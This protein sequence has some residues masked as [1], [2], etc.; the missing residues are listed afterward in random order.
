MFDLSYADSKSRPGNQVWCCFMLRVKFEEFKLRREFSRPHLLFSMASKIS[1]FGVVD[2]SHIMIVLT[3]QY[4]KE[5]L[6]VDAC[7]R[8]RLISH[9]GDG[10][11]LKYLN[12]A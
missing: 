2:A 7:E 11:I 10:R 3:F 12:R 5:E 4:S 1:F 6:F 8:S 9:S